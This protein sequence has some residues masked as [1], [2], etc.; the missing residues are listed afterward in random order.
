VRASIAAPYFDDGW[1]TAV[2]ME[3]NESVVK[4]KNIYSTVSMLIGSI[5]S[6]GSFH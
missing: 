4:L 2:E 1:W 3:K 6:F 5:K